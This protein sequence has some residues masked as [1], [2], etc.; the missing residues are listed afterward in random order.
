MCVVVELSARTVYVLCECVIMRSHSSDLLPSY[1]LWPGRANLTRPQESN[2]ID[3]LHNIAP[4]RF[5][6]AN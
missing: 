6:D 2:H 3:K 4:L 5:T 1:A